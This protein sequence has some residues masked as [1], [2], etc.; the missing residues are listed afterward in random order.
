MGKLCLYKSGLLYYWGE[1]R[2]RAF[3]KSAARRG[4]PKGG[5]V[6][7]WKGLHYENLHNLYW[8]INMIV[9][10]DRVVG[11]VTRYR[12]DGLGIESRWG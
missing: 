4:G 8:L 6:T 12:L 9:G 2:P 7:R 11:K 10:W 5:E 1:H 3:E